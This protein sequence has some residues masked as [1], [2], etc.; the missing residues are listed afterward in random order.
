MNKILKAA[1]KLKIFTFEDI[2]MFCDIDTETAKTF[3]Q[4]SENIKPVENKFEYVEK[5]KAEDKFMIVNKNIRSKNSDI[6][7][8]EACINFRYRKF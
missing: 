5:I 6:T 4:K 7:V 1:R 3:L 8:I 2:I